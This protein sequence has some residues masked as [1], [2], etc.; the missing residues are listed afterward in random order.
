MFWLSI[1][2]CM[3]ATS[4]G[5]T[6]SLT[7]SCDALMAG[8]DAPQTNEDIVSLI[9][10]TRQLVPE[11]DGVSITVQNIE[12]D[13]TFLAAQIELSTISNEPFEREYI[14]Q[15][16][17]QIYTGQISGD[18]T[19]AILV[20]EFKHIV[21][22]T[23]MDTNALVKF[24]LWYASGDV[25]EYERATDEFALE[26][27]CGLGLISFREWLYGMVSE[28]IRAEKERDYYTPDEIRAWMAAN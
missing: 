17:P 8:A 13:S 7:P 4:N 25:S 27:G 21:D 1:I 5:D 15:I 19:V 11:L 6:S 28:E 22:Y 16:N 14:V 9:N 10:D 23:E 12:S 2:G 26:R 24:G 18:S 20:H 3:Q